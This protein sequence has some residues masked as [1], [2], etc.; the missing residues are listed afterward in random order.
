MQCTYAERMRHMRRMSYATYAAYV[1][2]T[3][4]ARWSFAYPRGLSVWCC[5]PFS[6]QLTRA[7]DL[8]V[9]R[10][11]VSARSNLLLNRNYAFGPRVTTPC[12][13]SW[14]SPYKKDAEAPCA[15]L[16]QSC[17]LSPATRWALSFADVQSDALLHWWVQCFK[18]VFHHHRNLYSSYRCLSFSAARWLLWG[19]AWC[20]DF[21]LWC[22]NLNAAFVIVVAAIAIVVLLKFH[23]ACLVCAYQ[24][25]WRSL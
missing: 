11:S 13:A 2:C 19:H 20:Y 1:I 12:E 25:C 23:P 3:C 8:Q 10:I 5:L 22:V 16:V 21:R 14:R 7:T 17:R 15:P 4:L 9:W 18:A 6:C 24:E